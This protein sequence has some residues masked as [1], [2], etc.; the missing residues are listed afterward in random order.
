MVNKI[1]E[2][3]KEIEILRLIIEATLSA[4]RHIG[5]M[6]KVCAKVNDATA[7]CD[8]GKELIDKMLSLALTNGELALSFIMSDEITEHLKQSKK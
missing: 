3:E 1:E 4:R 6:K 7:K 8:C 2:L 5:E